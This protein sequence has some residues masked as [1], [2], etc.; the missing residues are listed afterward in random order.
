MF[1]SIVFIICLAILVLF[2]TNVGPYLYENTVMSAVSFVVVTMIITTLVAIFDD[3]DSEYNFIGTCISVILI[4]ILMSINGFYDALVETTNSFIIK[5]A[6]LEIIFLVMG[7]PALI[8]LNSGHELNKIQLTELALMSV[9][10]GLRTAG[11]GISNTDEFI[12][13]KAFWSF[14]LSIALMSPALSLYPKV[15]HLIYNLSE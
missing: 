7:T 10:Y 15:N 3:D 9:W 6:Y 11:E 8:C 5:I 4:A 1:L 12:A 14:V 13:W 2:C